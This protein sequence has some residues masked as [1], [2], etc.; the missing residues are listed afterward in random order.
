MFTMGEDMMKQW[1]ENWEKLMGDHLEKLVHNDKFISEMSKSI[2]ATMTGK[3]FYSKA[4]DEQ[5]AAMNL[6]SRTEIVKVLQK[7]TDIEERVIDLTERFEDY[8]DAQQSK[9]AAKSAP[10]AEKAAPEAKPAP[11]AAAKEVKARK[12][13]K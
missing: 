5:M 7:L 1:A 4:L 2:A 11:D 9:P 10:V 8:V 12:Q 6:P 13:K 3:A